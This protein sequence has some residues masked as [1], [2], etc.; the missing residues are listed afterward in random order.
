LEQLRLESRLRVKFSISPDALRWPVPPFLVQSLVENAVKHGISQR[1]EGGE[2]IIEAVIRTDR[3]QLTVS[4]SG[5]LGPTEG[6]DGIGL[7]NAR[8]RLRHLFGNTAC[9]SLQESSADVTSAELVVP[10]QANDQFSP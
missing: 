6:S 9:L 5:P 2:I 7:A 1:E 8:A 10:R 3:L 4:N